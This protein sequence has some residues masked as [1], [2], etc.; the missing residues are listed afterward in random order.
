MWECHSNGN[1]LYLIVGDKC[2]QLLNLQNLVTMA[3]FTQEIVLALGLTNNFC[4]HSPR[5]Q[6]CTVHRW[7]GLVVISIL[8]KQENFKV[9]INHYT[10]NQAQM[11]RWTRH[12]PLYPWDLVLLFIFF[13]SAERHS[14]TC[15]CFTCMALKGV[16]PETMTPI[17]ALEAVYEFS[18]SSNEGKY[19]YSFFLKGTYTIV[20]YTAA[21]STGV[22]S[23]EFQVDL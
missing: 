18:S 9:V 3:T 19:I 20:S 6:L 16:R 14:Q 12:I 22:W 21:T 7:Y 17:R 4:M 15:T 8:R 13:H 2:C 11:S 23:P 1:R 10:S 5:I